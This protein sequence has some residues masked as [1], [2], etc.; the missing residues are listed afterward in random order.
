[1]KP[2][3]VNTF[4]KACAMRRD[5]YSRGGYWIMA[6]GREVTIAQQRNGEEAKSMTSVPRATFNNLIR[7]YLRDQKLRAPR[8]GRGGAKRA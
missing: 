4:D 1:M 3:E 6:D 7:W 2:S 5:N 8:R